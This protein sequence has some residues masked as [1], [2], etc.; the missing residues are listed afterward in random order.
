MSGSIQVHAELVQVEPRAR[1]RIVCLRLFAPQV[2]RA[3]RPGQFVMLAPGPDGQL[4]PFLNRPFSIHRVPDADTLE[5][6]VAVVG[7]G[8]E[9]LAALPPGVRLR[10]LGPIGRGFDPPARGPLLLLGG[11]LGVAPLFF[12]AESLAGRPV[13][14]L[15]GAATAEALVSTAGLPCRVELATDD[16]S[17][18]RRG[19]ATELLAEALSALPVAERALAYLAACGPEPMLARA[20]ALCREAGVR[21]ELSLEAHMACGTGACMGC[22]RPIGG[23]PQRVC[24]EGPVFDAREVYP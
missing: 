19:L 14:L 23:R 12:L 2:A 10:L 15:Y 11:G 9:G 22:A 24:S 8:T 13:R 18:G 1:Q 7:R 17:A 3:A 21:A 16:G 20:A 5:L 4:D 6:L